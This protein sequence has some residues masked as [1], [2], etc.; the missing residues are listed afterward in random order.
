MATLLVKVFALTL[1][2]VAKPLANRF[3][4]YVMGHPRFRQSIVNFA[5]VTA[6]AQ[7]CGTQLRPA[8]RTQHQQESLLGYCLLVLCESFGTCLLLWPNLLLPTTRPNRLFPAPCLQ[9]LH[10]LEV[11]INRGAEGK[12]GGR[13][14]VGDMTEEKAVQLASKVASEGFVYFVSQKQGTHV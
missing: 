3:E 13:V 12:A 1:K 5:Q 2:T 11:T 14:F 10:R 7:A 9:R 4:A 8:T 6:Q